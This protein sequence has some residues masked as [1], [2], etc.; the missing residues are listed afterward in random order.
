MRL[1]TQNNN[2]TKQSGLNVEKYGLTT[3]QEAF[4]SSQFCFKIKYYF[5]ASTLK[6]GNRA[7]IPPVIYDMLHSHVGM[8]QMSASRKLGQGHC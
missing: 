4:N 5:A 8:F 3:H 1:W 7:T 2:N 6:V